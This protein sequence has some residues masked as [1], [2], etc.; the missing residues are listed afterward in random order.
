LYQ[1]KKGEA[2]TQGLHLVQGANKQVHQL[3]DITESLVDKILPPDMEFEYQEVSADGVAI[4]IVKV[5]KG[6]GN[7]LPRVTA[8]GTGLPKRL[9]AVA[10]SKIGTFDIRNATQIEVRAFI[11][12]SSGFR[13]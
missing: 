2:V 12:T 1:E 11:S 13:L 6:E 9:K 8:L 10:L 4:D 7:P 5:D 3:L